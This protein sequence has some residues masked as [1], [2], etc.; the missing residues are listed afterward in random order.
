MQEIPASV[1]ATVN[2]THRELKTK[3]K[4]SIQ[5]RAKASAAKRKARATVSLPSEIG[6]KKLPALSREKGEDE[7]T[8]EA[9]LDKGLGNLLPNAT[10]PEKRVSVGL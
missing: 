2:S 7:R 8:S 6:A 5:V 10:K 3:S 4:P 1:Q 9:V